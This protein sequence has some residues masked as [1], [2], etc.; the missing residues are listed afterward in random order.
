[1][2]QVVNTSIIVEYLWFYN[3][4][5]LRT[6]LGHTSAENVKISG[7]Q[8]KRSLLCPIITAIDCYCL[9]MRTQNIEWALKPDIGAMCWLLL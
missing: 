2:H 8:H 6:K 1:M 7:H 5:G 9:G 3:E 4:L